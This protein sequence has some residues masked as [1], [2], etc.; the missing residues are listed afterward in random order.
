MREFKDKD[1]RSVGDLETTS[2]DQ[3]MKEEGDEEAG[4]ICFSD[5]RSY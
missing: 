5:L 3:Q 2:S 1:V 4:M